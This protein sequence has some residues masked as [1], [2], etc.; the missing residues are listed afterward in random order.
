M[1]TSFNIPSAGQAHPSFHGSHDHPGLAV[2]STLLIGSW[3][4]AAVITGAAGLFEAGPSRPPL[5]LLVAVLGP[6]AAFSLA[7]ATAPQFKDFVLRFDLRMLTA[8]QSWRVLG[9]VFLFLYA[10]NLRPGL[11]AFPAGLGDAAVGVAAVFVLRAMIDGHPTWRRRVLLLNLGGLLDFVVAIGTGVLT[12]NSSLGFFAPAT[13]MP[14]MGMMP[15]SLI[16][17][18][19]VPLWI[20]I[21]IASLL[22]LRRGAR[23]AHGNDLREA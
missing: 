5:P 6:P 3:L 13:P 20:I 4:L 23:L 15:L 14:S 2:L 1:S 9:V 12:S 17:T 7:Y 11:F 21:H 19:A 22:Q 18:F 8:V 16:P 10:F